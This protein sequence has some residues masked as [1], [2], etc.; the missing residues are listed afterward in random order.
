MTD[1]SDLFR[2]FKRAAWVGAASMRIKML[3][4]GQTFAI[5]SP[6]AEATR[7]AKADLRDAV[8]ASNGDVQFITMIDGLP[9]P[10]ERIEH[11]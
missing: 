9:G 3:E 4:T 10:V 8:L 2:F 6:T 7:K 11:D 1:S 5:Y